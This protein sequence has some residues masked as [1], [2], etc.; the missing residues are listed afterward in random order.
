MRSRGSSRRDA[1]AIV[2]RSS[3]IGAFDRS[4]MRFIHDVSS[5][6]MSYNGS[7]PTCHPRRCARRYETS[8]HSCP[9]TRRDRSQTKRTIYS[10]SPVPGLRLR[11]AYRI[12]AAA[13]VR[14][15]DQPI[16][17]VINPVRAGTRL[18]GRIVRSH[19]IES[20]AGA[21][22][23]VAESVASARARCATLVRKVDTQEMPKQHAA[24]KQPRLN[25]YTIF[26]D[27]IV[28]AGCWMLDAAASV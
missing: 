6:R 1:G 17:I 28:T 7:S 12:Y 18:H 15:I 14:T 19:A 5:M 16:T 20:V 24:V 21:F 4:P 26:N 22:S 3:T 10:G 11:L 23:R 27:W 9:A 2:F 25:A 8:D 13:R